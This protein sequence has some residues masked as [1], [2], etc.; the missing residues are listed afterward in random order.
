[1]N[2]ARTTIAGNRRGWPILIIS[3][4]GLAFTAAYFEILAWVVKGWFAFDRSYSLLIL[5][6]SLFMVWT[7]RDPLRRTPADPCLVLGSLV[8]LAG[9]SI[10]VAGR[11]SNTLMVQGISLVVVLLGLILLLLGVKH[12]KMLFIPVGYLFFMFYFLE[13]LFGRFSHYLQLAS[14]WI[15]AHLIEATGM[16][17]AR[18]GYLIEL[19]HISLEVAK[20]CN[21][22][23]H[24]VA[25]A[26]MSVPFAFLSQK[27]TVGKG[28][29][30]LGA[31]LIGLFSNGLRVAM[32]G[33]WT[34]YF[35]EG[36]LHGPFD[37]F[38]VSF[39][40][41]FG[42]V[43]FGLQAMLSRRW[44]KGKS[45]NTAAH[46]S[47]VKG[48][49]VALKFGSKKQWVAV[50]TA[51]AILILT[52]AYIYLHTPVPVEP[53]RSLS[54]FPMQLGPWVGKTVADPDWPAKHLT[55]DVELRRIYRHP[56]GSEVGLYIGYFRT[57]EQNKELINYQLGWL[58]L[59][60]EE[61]SLSRGSNEIK[62]LKGVARG[63]NDQTYQGDKRT[64][65]FWY[66]IDDRIYL[67]QYRVKIALVLNNL[68]SRRSNGA[69]V[70]VSD[71]T[72]DGSDP[73]SRA[74]TQE[75]LEKILTLIP[76]YF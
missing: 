40:L 10:V 60:T 37:I 65:Y 66:Q 46:P 36:P 13:E 52:N 16:P 45:A 44:N 14:A 35:P 1:M 18:Q 64:F 30:V 29:I 21:G 24:I 22:I 11:L 8:T 26:A 48:S 31:F 27:S 57:Q 61:V 55:G 38:Y 49:P 75:F 58:H 59:K 41:I 54:E 67:D 4:L 9:C 25:L 76:G 50:S 17:V 53:K 6:L 69:L 72:G 70:L 68:L 62:I 20:V 5:S 63:L 23:N 39:I 15:A 74:R 51:L 12:F 28:L 47:P 33:Y 34:K 32:I 73:V 71:E 3:I 19:P 43:F 42:L 2:D 7:R 56:S